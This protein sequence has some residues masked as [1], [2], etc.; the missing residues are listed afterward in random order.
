MFAFIGAGCSSFSEKIDIAGI[1]DSTENWLFSEE[2]NTVE[3]EEK[4]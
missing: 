1:I 3:D 4:Y 2:G